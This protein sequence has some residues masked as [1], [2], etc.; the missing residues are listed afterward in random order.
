MERVAVNLANA[1]PRDRFESGLCTT[2]RDGILADQVAPDVTRVHLARAGRFDLGALRRLRSSIAAQEIDILHAHGTAI[3]AAVA[4]SVLR[5]RVSIV[6][7]DHYGNSLV[8]RPWLPFRLAAVRVSAVVSV[9]EALATWARETL[10]VPQDRVWYVPNFVCTP[11]PG[12]APASLPGQSGL[13]VVCVANFR[14]QKN[15][16]D[17]IRALAL[18]R[19]Q[20]PGVHLLLVGTGHDPD[21]VREI[22]DLIERHRLDQCVTLMGHQTN[23]SAILTACDVGVLSSVGEGMP[24]ALLE[25]GVAG[26]AAV[27]TTVGQCVEVLDDGRAGLLVPPRDPVAFAEALLSLLR[28][29]A[30]RKQL[31]GRL[32]ERVNRHFSQDSAVRQICAV[33]DAV[34]NQARVRPAEQ[35]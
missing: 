31:A 30:L 2:R 22:R 34:G 19:D 9:N 29:P 1:I 5:P 11:S 32:R 33:Y 35:E 20:L 12:G 24:L 14:P 27:S 15:H 28:E 26:L 6:W 4:A 13:R 21:Q 10:S 7:H 3:F 18:V 16:P 17:L 25:Y 23:V 8:P